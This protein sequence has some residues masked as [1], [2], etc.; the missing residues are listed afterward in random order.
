M[1][2]S[3]ILKSWI[4]RVDR[5]ALLFFAANLLMVWPIWSVDYLPWQD[6]PQ[7]LAVTRVL[8]SYNDTA[9]NFQHYFTKEWLRS[10]YVVYYLLTT[11]WGWVL[12]LNVASAITISLGLMGIPYSLRSLLRALDLSEWHAYLVM[13]LVFTAHVQAG[14]LTYIIAIP[15]ALWTISVA[16]RCATDPTRARL[17]ALGVSCCATYFSH[18]GPYCLALAGVGFIGVSTW[19]LAVAAV[20]VARRCGHPV[21]A[22]GPGV[23]ER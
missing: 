3:V 18:F 13:P 6:V 22:P 11:L 1:S 20:P 16:V 9:Y 8:L 12:P 7:H 14:F 5:A 2:A 21:D 10:P 15:L 23:D 4:T 19:S 17:V